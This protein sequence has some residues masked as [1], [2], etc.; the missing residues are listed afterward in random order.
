[1]YINNTKVENSET[2]DNLVRQEMSGKYEAMQRRGRRRSDV[3]G[4][5]TS[6]IQKETGD[7]E[8]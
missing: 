8:G 5:G 6:G 2:P 1:M 7:S 3:E 4:P